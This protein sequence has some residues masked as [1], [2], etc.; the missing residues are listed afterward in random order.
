MII[1]TLEPVQLGGTTQ[2]IRIRGTDRSNPVLLLAQQGP[3]LPIINDA[4]RLEGVLGLERDFTVVY[5]DQRGCGLSLR[6]SGRGEKLTVARMV[7]DT[8][9]LLQLLN[10]R[11]GGPPFVAGFSFGATFAARAAAQRPD[12]VAALIAT[13]MDIDIPFAE[14]HTYD[15]VLDAARAS[16]NRRALKQ[17]EAIGAPPHLDAKRFGTRVRWAVDFGGVTT[18]AT[19]LQLMRSMLGSLLRSSDYTLPDLVR[20]VRGITATQVALLVEL[21]DTDLVHDLPRIDVPVVMV[22]GRHDQVAPAVPAQRYFDVLTAPSKRLV[23]FENSAHTPHVDEPAAFRA[24]L[25]D[26]LAASINDPRPIRAE[27]T[28]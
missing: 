15:F 6:R 21:A 8:V 10:D 20:T 5:W 12:L 16:G 7:A 13:G 27:P 19:Y 14:R 9:E 3:G 28:R 2:W 1:D 18:G 22:Q 23:W 26:V 11:F 25:M 17:L 4:R 24:L